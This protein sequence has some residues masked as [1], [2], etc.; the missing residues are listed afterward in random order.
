[1]EKNDLTRMIY[2]Y[3]DDLWGKIEDAVETFNSK[4][5]EESCRSIEEINQRI[6]NDQEDFNL[7]IK[8]SRET[9]LISLGLNQEKI[10]LILRDSELS[11]VDRINFVKQKLFG[12]SF[13]IHIPRKHILKSEPVYIGIL[14]SVPFYLDDEF[15]QKLM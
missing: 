1:M 12:N 8:K 6:K 10:N 11:E 15:V 3:Y 5:D 2:Q 7:A 4:H 9:N 14:F 13:C